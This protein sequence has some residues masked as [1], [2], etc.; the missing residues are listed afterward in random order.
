MVKTYNSKIPAYNNLMHALDLLE[1]E[2]N[3]ETMLYNL[4][5]K[6]R[7]ALYDHPIFDAPKWGA[8]LQ[9]LLLP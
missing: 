7:E 3:V 4:S 2:D 1:N 9:S 6:E 5:D 8:K